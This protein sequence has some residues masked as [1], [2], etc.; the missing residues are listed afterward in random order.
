[1][2]QKISDYAENGTAVKL[3]CD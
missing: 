1:M 3:W 2:S